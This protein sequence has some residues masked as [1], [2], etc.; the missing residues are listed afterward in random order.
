[1]H[2]SS[3]VHADGP[4]GNTP[5]VKRLTSALNQQQQQ[6]EEPSSEKLPRARALSG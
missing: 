1:M 3:F 6:E 5:A 2:T 4:G